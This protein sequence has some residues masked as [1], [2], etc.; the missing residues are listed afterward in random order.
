MEGAGG[1]RVRERGRALEQPRG[2]ARTLGACNDGD[3][4]SERARDVAG[5]AAVWDLKR[6]H[7]LNTLLCPDNN[8]TN[9]TASKKKNEYSRH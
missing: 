4:T 7:K 6:K 8:D 2:A 3:K 9:F 1:D 5:D